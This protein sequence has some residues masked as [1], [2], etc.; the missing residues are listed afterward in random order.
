MLVLMHRGSVFLFGELQQEIL[1]PWPRL[2]PKREK[3]EHS[4]S[5]VNGISN[6]ST[7]FLSKIIRMVRLFEMFFNAY[8]Y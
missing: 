8:S 2:F 6:G 7:Y 4:Y 3:G 5:T 1:I